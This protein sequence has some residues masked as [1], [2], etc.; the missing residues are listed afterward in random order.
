MFHVKHRIDLNRRSAPDLAVATCGSPEG[1]ID[2]ERNAERVAE[3]REALI[4][5]R[6]WDGS[7]VESRSRFV[8][9]AVRRSAPPPRRENAAMRAGHF[10]DS[11][12]A[13]SR[14]TH[15]LGNAV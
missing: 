4:V 2:P 6:L 9:R 14:R 1:R 5:S 12:I 11:Q 10:P 8:P 15:S 3:L 13:G 7:F